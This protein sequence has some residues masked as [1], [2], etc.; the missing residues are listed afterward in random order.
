MS[1]RDKSKELDMLSTI[2]IVCFIII[3][4]IA[5]LTGNL[6]EAIYALLWAVCLKL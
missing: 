2:G 3:S 4:M 6:D 1:S 5:F